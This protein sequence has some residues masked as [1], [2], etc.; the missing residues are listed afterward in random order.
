MSLSGMCQVHSTLL[1]WQLSHFKKME[2]FF[3]VIKE[4]LKFF[5]KTQIYF[6]LINTHSHASVSTTSSNWDRQ[7]KPKVENGNHIYFILVTWIR[8]EGELYITVFRSCCA[9]S[10]K[11]CLWNAESLQHKQPFNSSIKSIFNYSAEMNSIQ[12]IKFSWIVKIGDIQI[13]TTNK[14]FKSILFFGLPCQLRYTFVIFSLMDL[15]YYKFQ[16]DW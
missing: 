13:H 14:H 10:I 6:K 8:D 12:L 1:T 15:L 11:T 2:F 9:V 5:H 4:N 16:L 7:C 3:Q